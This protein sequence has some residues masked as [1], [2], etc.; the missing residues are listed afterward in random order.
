MVIFLIGYPLSGKTTIGKELARRLG[1]AYLGTGAYARSL[2]MT[3]EKSIV[4]QDFSVDFNDAIEQKVWEL[5]KKGNCVI[6]G[7]PRSEEQMM[8]I[9]PLQNKRIIFLYANAVTIADRLKH[10]VLTDKRTEDTD[11]IVSNRIRAC[12]KL[13]QVLEQAVDL[14]VIDTTD[15]IA[16]ENI[17][18]SFK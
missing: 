16:I 17:Y 9:L 10:R 18:R 12:M 8:K 2:G 15:V 14:E 3:L 13:K 4:T 1:Y 6:D 11:E 5:I 7:Y